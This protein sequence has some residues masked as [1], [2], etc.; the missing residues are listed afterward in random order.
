M[1][2]AIAAPP[3]GS[4]PRTSARA[5]PA[6]PRASPSLAMTALLLAASGPFALADA[7]S[8]APVGSRPAPPRVF[9]PAADASALAR[10]D[11]DR[12]IRDAFLGADAPGAMLV[13]GLPGYAAARREALAALTRCAR[14]DPAALHAPAPGWVASDAK[15]SDTLDEDAA[16]ASSSLR[17]GSPAAFDR[18]TVAALS[19]SR[20]DPALDARCGPGTRASLE[21]L[22]AS[23]DE[24]ARLV[25]PRLDDL[26]G[27]DTGGFFRAAADAGESLDHFHVYI[28]RESEDAAAKD[29]T[30][31]AT[32]VGSPP[33]DVEKNGEKNEGSKKNDV[34]PGPSGRSSGRRPSSGRGGKDEHTDVGVAIVMTPAL[35]AT[36]AGG[37]E[38]PDSASPRGLVVGGRAPELPS[39]AVVVMLGEAA[40]AWLPKPPRRPDGDGEQHDDGGLGR[41]R[42]LAVPTH[43]MSLTAD[44]GDADDGDADSNEG[45]DSARILESW[46]SRAW[47]GRMVFPST[48]ATHPADP[49]LTFEAWR[50]RAFEAFAAVA[51]GDVSDE[52][53]AEA[54]EAACGGG[55][56]GRGFGGGGEGFEGF[57]GFGD[58]GSASSSLSA[59]SSPRRRA[60]ADDGDACGA[61]KLYCWLSCVD[62][63]AC[64]V[65]AGEELKCV[66]P[67]TGLFWPEDLGAQAH[68]Y[69]CAPRCVAAAAPPAAASP[70]TSSSRNAFC[71]DKIAPVSMY[72]DGFLGWSDAN[73]PCVAFLHRDVELTTPGRMTAA[74][75][76]TA[77]LGVS[78]EAL[79]ALRRWRQRTQ[80]DAFRGA[81][82]T[83]GDPTA[84]R[85]ALRT[86]TMLLY[87][88]QVACG[89][90]LMLVAMTYHA[91]LFVG[92][93]VGLAA[94]HAGF[95]L[96]A[97]VPVGGG[98]SA[99]CQHVA[100]NP[101]VDE[102]EGADLPAG[103]VEREMVEVATVASLMREEE[104]RA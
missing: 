22:R 47:F 90:L 94:G 71:N 62:A 51:R 29:A 69:D 98:A 34:D 99:C 60:L 26:L 35:V 93:V 66:E 28:R 89:Y 16:P 58:G 14:A 37:F 55:G 77:F 85:V 82:E 102:G 96:S 6:P 75:F 64:D 1:P 72:M 48:L 88:I 10:G 46:R 80:D 25:L 63:P 19:A 39:D 2:G 76:F 81:I 5:R 56:F 18:R 49:S 73:A 15:F 100:T 50:N 78:V 61:G 86:Q 36:D 59:S 4:G 11:S 74:M 101:G 30:R 41:A 68:C 92:V 13:R 32:E 67:G 45:S 70:S 38:P 21:A 53:L 83:G 42:R 95:N 44:H 65:A 33:N 7:A 23:A 52:A 103:D 31:E 27:Y 20:L 91:A 40:D 84:V 104:G 87:T 8:A 12:T 57:S 24:A 79:A 97:P 43:E 9:L 54:A 3:P 17:L